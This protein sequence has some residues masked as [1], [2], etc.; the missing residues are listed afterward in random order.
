MDFFFTGAAAKSAALDHCVAEGPTRLNV[1][2]ELR[3]DRLTVASPKTFMAAL[4]RGRDSGI[5]LRARD[6]V[7]ERVAVR[8]SERTWGAQAC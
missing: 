8:K 2:L 6:C 7:F 5:A 1:A 3:D 4:P